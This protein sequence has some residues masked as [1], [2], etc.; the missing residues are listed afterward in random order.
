MYLQVKSEI[1]HHCRRCYSASAALC[2][3]SSRDDSIEVVLG[4]TYN[5][6][7]VVLGQQRSLTHCVFCLD[8]GR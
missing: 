3:T 6:N 5:R 2:D 1:E 7:I 4:Y 8:D